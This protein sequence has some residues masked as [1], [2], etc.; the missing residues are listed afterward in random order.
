MWN[1]TDM[2]AKSMTGRESNAITQFSVFLPNRLGHLNQL[3][4]LLQAE[5]VHLMAATVLD[6]TDSAILR[7]VVD[8]PEKT[9]SLLSSNAFPVTESD[10]VAVELASPE[11]MR[12]LISALLEA[13]LNINYLYS[14]ILHPHGK[15]VIGLSMEDNDMAEKVLRRHQFSVLKQPDI[16]R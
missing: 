3:V 11:E 16:S 2:P 12:R 9:R 13:E 7:F 14:F 4:R 6:N 15:S 1:G 10:L 5:N 8:D